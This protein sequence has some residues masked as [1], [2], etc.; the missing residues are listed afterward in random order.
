MRV[1]TGTLRIKGG[2][3]TFLK[4]IYKIEEW[5]I[6]VNEFIPYDTKTNADYARAVAEAHVNRGFHVRIIHNGK[7]VWEGGGL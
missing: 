1:F 4:P 7:T 6:A 3:G 5:S 2:G